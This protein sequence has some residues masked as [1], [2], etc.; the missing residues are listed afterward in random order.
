[1][2]DWLIYEKV[3]HLTKKR[4]CALWL[5]GRT[6]PNTSHILL[7]PLQKFLFLCHAV[8]ENAAAGSG[9]SHI[10]PAWTPLEE[11]LLPTSLHITSNYPATPSDNLP[12]LSRLCNLQNTMQHWKRVCSRTGNAGTRSLYLCHAWSELKWQKFVSNGWKKL[13]VIM[14]VIWGKPLNQKCRLC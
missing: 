1:M 2:D 10:R 11:K 3:Y 14:D 6:Y 12:W 8:P 9:R 13:L 5:N 7:S 4:M